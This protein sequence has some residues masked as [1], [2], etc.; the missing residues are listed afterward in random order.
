MQ[1]AKIGSTSTYLRCIMELEYWNYIAYAP[2]HN[3]FKG[4]RIKMFDF[5]T[6]TG[7]VV[8][9]SCNKIGT[10]NGQAVVP[11]IKLI[12]TIDNQK[13]NYKPQNL[14]KKK[15][16]DGLEKEDKQKESV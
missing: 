12:Q 1:Y 5:G 3:P 2:S 6:S 11:I 13:N 10:S 14:K 16:F 7:Q 8:D 9:L 15:D 4:S